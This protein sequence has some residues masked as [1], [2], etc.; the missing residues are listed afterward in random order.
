MI[1]KKFTAKT[2]TE[3]IANAKR[4]LGEG[5]DMANE[6]LNDYLINLKNNTLP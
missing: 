5:L 4:E 2:E 3:A 6:K 1:I